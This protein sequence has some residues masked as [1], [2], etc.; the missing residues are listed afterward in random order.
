MVTQSTQLQDQMN[1]AENL[2]QIRQIVANVERSLLEESNDWFG[3][4]R[5][6]DIELI[7]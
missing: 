5:F 3:V 1:V 6:H 7:T 4:M 2:A